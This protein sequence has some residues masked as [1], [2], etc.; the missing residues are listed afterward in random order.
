[1]NDKNTEKFNNLKKDN[2][3]SLNL[4]E[5]ELVA[6]CNRYEGTRYYQDGWIV[7][8]KGRIWSLYKNMWLNPRNQNGYWKVLNE[9]VHIFVDYYFFDDDEKRIYKT[10]L[11][12]NEKCN[13]NDQWHSH[14]HHKHSVI[15]IDS[16]K[17]SKDERIQACMTINYKENLMFQIKETDHKNNHRIM[18]GKKTLGEESGVEQFDCPSS[19]I[20]NSLPDTVYYSYDENGNKLVHMTKK[21]KG[22]TPDEI[23]EWDMKV[24][25]KFNHW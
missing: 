15:K 1:M 10:L 5:G 11:E 18:K 9:Y 7:T 23:K 14:V 12:H 16:T 2:F 17:M 19:I 24:P 21:L 13:K 22:M 4:K 20:K 8:N 25:H 6:H 3:K